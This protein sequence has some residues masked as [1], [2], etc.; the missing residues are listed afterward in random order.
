MTQD[1]DRRSCAVGRVDVGGLDVNAELVRCGDAWVYRLYAH[2]PA[3][4]PLEAKAWADSWRCG[5]CWKASGLS[6]VCEDAA[7]G[8][9]SANGLRLA[10]RV[11]HGT[12]A[13]T[14]LRA[15]GSA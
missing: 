3:L 7:V 6:T 2:D 4:L 8:L 1:V 5:H 12:I 13:I 11:T 15:G 9:I 14:D 10:A